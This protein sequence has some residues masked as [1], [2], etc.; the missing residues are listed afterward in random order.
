MLAGLSD[1]IEINITNSNIL[2]TSVYIY[3]YISYVYIRIWQIETY[4]K[5]FSLQIHL[6]VAF[7]VNGFR[8]RAQDDVLRLLVLY[9]H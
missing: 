2:L 6:S 7:T 5:K 9:D 1:M 4:R 3:I 8:A